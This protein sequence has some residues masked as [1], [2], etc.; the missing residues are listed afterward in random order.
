MCGIVGYTHNSRRLA[1]G[2]LQAGIA[3]L[4]HRGPDQQGSFVSPHVS[5]GAT[6]LRILDLEGGDQPM[7]SADGDTVIAFNGEIYNFRELRAELEALGA[8]SAPI[9]IPK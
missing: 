6:R 9:A 4:I 7:R 8:R 2:V 5:L 3:A 1:S